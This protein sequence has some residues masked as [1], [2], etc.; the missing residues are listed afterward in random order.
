CF[1]D[2]RLRIA[3]GPEAFT[4]LVD[5]LLQPRFVNGCLPRIDGVDEV[6]IQVGPDDRESFAG[7]H[8]RQR[9]AELAEAYHRYL[10]EDLPYVLILRI[11]RGRGGSSGSNDAGKR[12]LK[13]RQVYGP[14]PLASTKRGRF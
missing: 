9:R 5:E 10:H 1:R 12:A 4:V 2:G 3:G 7:Q 13:T 14:L 6:D 11:P 8:G